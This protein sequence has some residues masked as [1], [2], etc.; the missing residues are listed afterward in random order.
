VGQ[1][2]KVGW[3]EIQAGLLLRHFHDWQ[4]VRPRPQGR[5]GGRPTG[6]VVGRYPVQVEE[7]DGARP[8]DSGG[9]GLVLLPAWLRHCGTV[10][11]GTEQVLTKETG[12][13]ERT[14]EG[15]AKRRERGTAPLYPSRRGFTRTIFTEK[16]LC[17]DRSVG[18][19]HCYRHFPC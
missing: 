15:M 1:I 13:E 16:I 19:S 3:P 18:P 6:L 17:F 14:V 4:H 2:S 8:G 9:K 5:D 11:A 7:G 12:Q 10:S